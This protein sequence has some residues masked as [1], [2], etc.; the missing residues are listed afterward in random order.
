MRGAVRFDNETGLVTREV[1]NEA[2]Q[3]RL[4]AK[5]KPL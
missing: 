4:S 5:S 2:A 3:D 1:D